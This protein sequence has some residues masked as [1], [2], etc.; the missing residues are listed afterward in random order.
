M[1]DSIRHQ[2]NP[3]DVIVTTSRIEGAWV[4]SVAVDAYRGRIASAIQSQG[5]QII[6]SDEA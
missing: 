6:V 3:P 4:I 2:P 1:N 5:A